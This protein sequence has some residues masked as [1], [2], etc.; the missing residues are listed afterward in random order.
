MAAFHAEAGWGI[1]SAPGPLL[2]EETQ[3]SFAHLFR[4]AEACLAIG[5]PLAM[6]CSVRDLPLPKG[7]WQADADL[8]SW[9]SSAGGR[10]CTSA[11][12]TAWGLIPVVKTLPIFLAPALASLR[13]L[14]TGVNPSKHLFARGAPGPEATRPPPKGATAEVLVGTPAFSQF[15]WRYAHAQA[16]KYKPDRANPPC[17][18]LQ[19]WD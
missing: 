9:S 19:Q 11:P 1:V 7:E 16:F 18:F 12:N 13:S 2:F 8:S 6:V 5:S 14:A 15:L 10:P 3:N 4:A 17:W